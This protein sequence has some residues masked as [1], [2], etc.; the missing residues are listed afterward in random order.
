M[1]DVLE[2][3]PHDLAAHGEANEVELEAELQVVGELG[4]VEGDALLGP[5]RVR[6]ALGVAG[7]IKGQQVNA[8]LL[9]KLLHP[10]AVSHSVKQINNILSHNKE[11]SN[12]A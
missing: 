2:A 10:P 1:W 12:K 4:D 5:A 8:Q 7:A 3:A 6:V 9:C 11:N